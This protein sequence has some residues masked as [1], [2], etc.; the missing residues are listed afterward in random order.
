MGLFY[1]QIA[2]GGLLA[3]VMYS[4]I[5]VGFVLIYKSSKI[6]NFAQGAMVLGAALT[7]V[8]FIEMGVPFWLS[9]LIT[10][11]I[12]IVF[13]VAVERF[14]LRKLAN[15]SLLTLF[16]ATV[17][18]A[19]FVEGLAQFVWGGQVHGLELGIEDM[20][21]SVTS[22]FTV[23]QFDLFAA[24][25]AGGLVIVLAVLFTYT[26][27][28]LHLQAVADNV[29]ASLS[30]G[31]PIT[32]MWMIAW[33]TAGVIAIVAG[34]MWGARLGVQYTLS[35]VALKALPV[36]IM[37]GFTSI[38]GAIIAGL[39]VGAV[40]AIGELVLGPIIGWGTQIWIAYAV[41]LIVVLI[42]PSGMF[43]QKEVQRI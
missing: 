14:A 41:A 15:T 23:S 34:L 11:L 9:L 7:F 37:G 20:P 21:L 10:T 35:V 31:I 2:V 5:A 19:F 13:G 27:T 24:A 39:I 16:M 32:R 12:M 22:G 25:V 36:F 38:S 18:L 29:L 26:R 1:L 43:G 40:E 6:F 28:G 33:A 30:V 42:R 4:L 3:G 17:G 8:S